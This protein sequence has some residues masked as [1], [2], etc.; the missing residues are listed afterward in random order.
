MTRVLLRNRMHSSAPDSV[1]SQPPGLGEGLRAQNIWALYQVNILGPACAVDV[2]VARPLMNLLSRFNLR[3]RLLACLEL[4]GR[5]RRMDERVDTSLVSQ[6]PTQRINAAVVADRC[7]DP[8]G[9]H[10][11]RASGAY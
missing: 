2:W 1:Q 8:G 11:A 6:E 9:S 7:R 10:W 4:L 3:R 5:F